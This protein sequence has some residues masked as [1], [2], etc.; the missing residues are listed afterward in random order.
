MS[1]NGAESSPAHRS[2]IP[3]HKSYAHS[4]TRTQTLRPSFAYTLTSRGCAQ[5]ANRLRPLAPRRRFD[6]R[7][8][9]HVANDCASPVFS[10]GGVLRLPAKS[11]QARARLPCGL[12]HVAL[13]AK[14]PFCP[15]GRAD[16]AR[17]SWRRKSRS[18]RQPS[19]HPPNM[20]DAQERHPVAAES[21][22]G[23]HEARDLFPIAPRACF[24]Y[25]LRLLSF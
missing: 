11:P 3:P 12:T 4:K 23:P 8:F 19:P 16:E 22:Q 20:G 24:P 6:S 10:V 17:R 1:Q 18:A 15:R 13:A 7:G 21:D 5:E 2:V 9:P 25:A 14:P